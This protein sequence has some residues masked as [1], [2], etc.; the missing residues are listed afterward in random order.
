MFSNTIRQG[1]GGA[2]SHPISAEIMPSTKIK[3]K[4]AKPITI[5]SKKLARAKVQCCCDVKPLSL[6]QAV[7]TGLPDEMLS[8]IFPGNCDVSLAEKHEGGVPYGSH[9]F[10]LVGR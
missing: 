4:K 7:I 8:R 3:K 9:R 5:W 10:T 2:D 1:R 6:L